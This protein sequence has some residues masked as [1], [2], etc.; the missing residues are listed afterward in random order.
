LPALAAQ[1]EA[2]AA[3]GKP[4][5]AAA[6]AKL[7]ER[8]R[9]AADALA[10]LSDRYASDIAPAVREALGEAARTAASAQQLLAKAAAELPAVGDA[11]SRAAK[12]LDAGAKE[13]AAIK[14]AFPSAKAKLLQ[15]NH[16]IR[17]LEKKAD[18][19]TI[20]DLLRN[21]YA[22]ESAFFAEP[23]ILQEHKLFPIPNYGSAMSPFFSTLSLWVGATLLVS[24]LSVE[25]HDAGGHGGSEHAESARNP[26]SSVSSLSA[27]P[28]PSRPRPRQVR[29]ARWHEDSI[30]FLGRFLTFLTIALVQSALI[31]IGDLY[32]LGT[33]AAD[34][35][36]F[37]LFGLFIVTV[38]MLM[39][40]TLVSVF[41]N[42]GKAMAIILLVLQLGGS[43]GTFPIQVAPP[44]F[45]H[46]HPYLPFTYAISMMREAVGGVIWDVVYRDMQRLVIFVALFLVIGLVLK[47]PVNRLAKGM[48]ER[49]KRG[50]LLH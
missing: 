47:S 24:L 5:P 41:G 46:I 27:E 37:I 3:A 38:F 1:L 9:L 36:M 2:A 29:A 6:L 12:A 18:I 33:Y 49:A 26:S 13:A 10:Q 4:L 17:E 40:Y 20:I 15:V 42:V 8:S 19:Q 25:A 7:R 21:D 11:L 50:G 44:F 28:T 22:K 35:L 48:L 43:G 30:V 34:H 16:D 31:T 23:V 14:R 32:L 39:V 45:R